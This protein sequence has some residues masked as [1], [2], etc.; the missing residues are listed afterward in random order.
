MDG[1]AMDPKVA[2][3]LLIWRERMARAT[4]EALDELRDQGVDMEELLSRV[5]KLRTV[6]EPS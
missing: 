2:R 6:S 1:D 4:A 3:I 5:S